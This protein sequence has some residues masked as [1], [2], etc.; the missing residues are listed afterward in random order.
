MAYKEVR[1]DAVEELNKLLFEP[2]YQSDIGRYR[3]LYLYRGLSNLNYHLETSLQRCC[4]S[5]KKEMENIEEHLL[6]NFA[7]YAEMEHPGIGQSVWNKMI[8]GQHHGLPTRLMDWT[9]S[10]M[11]A[12]H[13]ATKEGNIDQLDRHDCVV[14]RLDVKKLHEHLDAPYN[15][16]SVFSVETLEKAIESRIQQSGLTPLEQYDKDMEENKGM[17]ILEPPTIDQRIQ[18]QYS[19]FSVVPSYVDRVEEILENCVDGAV[20]KYIIDR[21]LRWR[22]RDMLDEGN[23]NE[24]IIMPGLDGIA[25]W[26]ARHYHV[27]E[28]FHLD[29][30]LRNITGVTSDVIV[31]PTDGAREP[32]GSLEESIFNAAGSEQLIK[33]CQENKARYEKAGDIIVTDSFELWDKS[34]IKC[35][36]HALGGY[37]NPADPKGS[38]QMLIKLYDDLLELVLKNRCSSVSFPLLCSGQKGF[39]PSNA[40]GCALAACERFKKRHSEKPTP[41]TVTFCVTTDKT[42]QKGLG[43]RAELEKVFAKGTSALE[44]WFAEKDAME[45]QA[46]PQGNFNRQVRRG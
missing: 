26:M 41:M 6:N 8:V 24:R 4:K 9:R 18:N 10:P 43:F 12:L 22:I 7:K 3:Q 37:W 34:G 33:A 15:Y 38:R 28:M 13:F 39:S 19:F 11:I 42:Y 44:N 32:V 17:V 46:F 29:I 35:V 27:R 23:V 16:G 45:A 30:S 36:F 5:K 1:I 2:E 40:W 21:N 31:C 14:W 25:Q 20:V